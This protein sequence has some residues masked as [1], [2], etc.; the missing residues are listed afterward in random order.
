VKLSLGGNLWHHRDF[1][2][3]WFSETVSSFG[4]NFSGVALPLIAF[5]L[6]GSGAFGVGLLT[7]LAIVPYPVL[8][9]FVG[10]WTDRFRK[11]RI[12][13][14]CNLGRMASLMTVPAA[15]VFG[16]LTL[17]QL[18][19]VAL[20]NG[21]FSVFFD[22][23]YQAYLP[24]LIERKDLIEGNQKL[25][26]SASGATVAGPSLAGGVYQALT[27]EVAP[28]ILGAALAC[29]AD[30]VGY[31]A[32]AVALLDIRKPEPRKERSPGQPEPDFFGEMKEG[33]RIVLGN[34]LL[35]RIAG[36]TATSNLG[37]YM[38][39]PALFAF[40]FDRLDFT[41]F[42]WGL[43]GTIG[44]LGFLLGAVLAKRASSFL[45]FGRGLAVS[46]S[47]AGLAVLYPLAAYGVPFLLPALVAF[48]VGTSSPIYN[49]NQVSLRQAI[50]PD[51]L[52]GRMNATMRVIVWGTIPVGALLGGSLASLPSFGPV[53]TMVLGGALA[54]AAGLWILLG[55]V[56][57]LRVQP[58]PLPEGAS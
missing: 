12:M 10:V 52:Q 50:T 47:V 58:E 41:P 20:V 44:A 1:S 33:L 15:A 23:S 17:D 25:Q 54:G 48:V 29:L 24:L 56:V 38:V 6:L 39:T 32:A 5:K 4:S 9:L 51:R 40:A 14:V 21:V 35:T 7:A 34:P 22:I 46:A 45:G 26:L 16:A 57:S 30:A 3:L 11:K 13:V 53:Y 36:C 31:L 55:P 42:E 8:G 27:A 37:S 19:A 18:Y 49:I 28:K 2:R 43:L